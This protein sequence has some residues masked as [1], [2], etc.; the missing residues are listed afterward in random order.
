MLVS[1]TLT[2]MQR[3]AGQCHTYT[4]MQRCAVQCHC[5]TYTVMQRCAGQY[6]TDTYTV[7]QRCAGQCHTYTGKPDDYKAAGS[8]LATSAGLL[9]SVFAFH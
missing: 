2:V 4:V 7:M 9:Y 6:N 8:L 3:C 1:V 5:H